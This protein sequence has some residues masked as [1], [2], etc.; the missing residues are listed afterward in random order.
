[1]KWVGYLVTLF[2]SSLGRGDETP[3]PLVMWHG[4]RDTCCSDHMVALKTFIELYKP[5]IY[6]RSIM[7]GKDIETDRESSFYGNLNG[8][9]DEV[10]QKL[11]MDPKLQNGYNAMGFSQGG[12]FF[13]AVAQRC[14]YP[15]M[16]NLITIGSPHQGVY[17]C[18]STCKYLFEWWFR[19][20]V[21]YSHVQQMY[22]VA[23]YWHDPL[24][25]EKYRESS[26]FLADI[27]N[28]KE[29]NE[30]YKNNLK[31]L[32]NF[33]MV[34]FL[35]D[36]TVYPT[37]SQWFGFYAQGQ[38]EV[39]LPLRESRLYQEDR[40]GLKEMDEAGKLHFLSVDADHLR[41]GVEWFFQE[42]VNKFVV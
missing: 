26:I 7:I 37:E 8:Q 5:G 28:E 32:Q 18:G 9:V 14:P 41:F 12:L 2:V 23:Q 6:I 20:L 16:M 31:K 29:I 34:K 4:L 11:A 24:D 30:T 39:E 38:D 19:H 42:I 40:L 3:T 25:E 10:C 17:G 36:T 13:R 35:N 27:N 22:V 33:V 1:M 15:S 21:Y